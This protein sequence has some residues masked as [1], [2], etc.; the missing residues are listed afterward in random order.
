[1]SNNLPVYILIRTSNRPKFFANLMRTIREQTYQNIITIVHTD[2]PADEYV[3]GDIIIRGARLSHTLGTA[4]YNLY[5]NRLL[6]AIPD[7]AGWY[8]FI[9]DDDMYNSPDVIERLVSGSKRGCVNVGRVKRW[10]ETVWP[11]RWGNQHSFQTECFFLHTDHKAIGEWWANKGGDHN[12]SK[13]LTKVLPTNWIDNLFICRAQE[14]KGHGRR[15]DYGEKPA[16]FN[17]G[18][19][20]SFHD[21]VKVEYLRTIR[22]PLF[23][24]GR[25]GEIKELR[26]ERALRLEKKGKVRIIREGVAV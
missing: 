3:A 5:N 12:Y 19:M 23:L 7:G 25:L 21:M 9:D 24:K 17:T 4:P 10:N 1:M 26:K 13:Q 8:H 14:G 22:S 20:P 15:Y 2:D 6:Q 11:R 18:Y 16:N